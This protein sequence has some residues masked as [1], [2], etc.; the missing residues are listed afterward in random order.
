MVFEEYDIFKSLVSLNQEELFATMKSYLKNKYKK[1]Y[2]S[3]EFMVAIG[4][5]PIA[6]VAHLDTVYSKPV[7]NLYYDEKQSV[8]WSPEGLG[9]DDRAGVFIILQIIK[10]G[11]RP[12]IILTTDEEKGGLGALALSK[13]SCPIKKPKYM[14]Q[15]D[16][17]GYNDCVFYSCDNGDFVKYVESFG[18]EESYGSFSDISFLMPE[19]D[20]CGVNLSVGYE[21]EH[22]YSERLHVDWMFETISK[23]EKMLKEKNIPDFKY[24]EYF[25]PYSALSSFN[26]NCSCCGRVFSEYEM[27]PVKTNS[28]KVA[29]YCPDCISVN[30][31]WCKNCS[32]PFE[33]TNPNVLNICNDCLKEETV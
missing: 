10:K 18:F 25:R 2:S 30:V 19:W 7:L 26:E 22:S 20:I 9:A 23:V 4:N 1:V 5:I 13:M 14:I 33:I 16:R 21:D 6:L 32:E 31:G 11:L 15:L 12:S 27:F 24:E 28:G 17:R 29:M 3:K 8:L